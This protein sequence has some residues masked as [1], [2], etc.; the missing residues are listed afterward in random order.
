[1]CNHYLLCFEL[2]VLNRVFLLP[3]WLERLDSAIFVVCIFGTRS[4]I[5]VNQMCCECLFGLVLIGEISKGEVAYHDELHADDK[6]YGYNLAQEL[7]KVMDDSKG[8]KHNAPWSSTDSKDS[9][10]ITINPSDKN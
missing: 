8:K 4:S 1:M 7:K 5:Y 6:Q 9:K 2:L 10:T 3:S